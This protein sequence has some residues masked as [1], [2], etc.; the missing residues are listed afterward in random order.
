MSTDGWKKAKE[1]WDRVRWAREQH[2]ASAAAAAEAMGM[3]ASTYRQYE[4]GP[5]SSRWATLDYKY[6][7]QFG[8]KFN[9]SWIWLLH[10]K[11]N[12]FD[13]YY[14]DPGVQIMMLYGE[15][16]ERDREYVLDLMRRLAGKAEPS[17]D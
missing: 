17:A 2:F 14:D 3:P 7:L 11:D 9:V 1:S 13:V 5:G 12:P 15:M 4:R 10:G 6:A 16:S 8:R